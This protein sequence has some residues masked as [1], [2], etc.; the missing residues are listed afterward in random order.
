MT[1]LDG[2][3]VSGTGLE[4]QRISPLERG[5]DEKE[6]TGSRHLQIGDRATNQFMI[7]PILEVND[8]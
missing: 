1:G 7:F 3:F 4:D 8:H 2:D 5:C 6:L